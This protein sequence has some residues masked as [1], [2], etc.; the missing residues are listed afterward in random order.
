MRQNN[1]MKQFASFLIILLV[2]AALLLFL[3][4]YMMGITLNDIFP[5]REITLKE[6]NRAIPP[7]K[8]QKE[9]A[10]QETT[11]ID[12]LETQG[13]DRVQV[14][15]Y[16][17]VGSFGNLIQAQQKAK[18]L[19]NDFNTNVIILPPTKEGYYRISYAK[20]STLEEAKATIKSIRTNIDSDA[21]IFSVKE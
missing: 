17:I 14:D 6:L 11:H 19:I 4:N 12:S 15:Y 5:P 7:H 13:D 2:F 20:Y 3:L 10:M 21:W 1:T 16:I 9:P 8:S 18:R